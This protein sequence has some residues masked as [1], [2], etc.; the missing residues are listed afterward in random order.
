[1]RKVLGVLGAAALFGLPLWGAETTPD[2]TRNV[3]EICSYEQVK[4]AGAFMNL[5]LT[6]DFSGSMQDRV[7]S[8]DRFYNPSKIYT[9]Y[10]DPFGVYKK[11]EDY[12]KIQKIELCLIKKI[13]KK[14]IKKSIV[15]EE[16]KVFD[17]YEKVSDLAHW[18]LSSKE[19]LWTKGKVSNKYYTGNYLN[20]KYLQRA[21]FEKLLLTGGKVTTLKISS[22]Y[23]GTVCGLEFNFQT[24]V[25]DNTVNIAVPVPCF[26][27]D[28]F[29]KPMVDMYHFAKGVTKK[30]YQHH[31]CHLIPNPKMRHECLKAPYMDVVYKKEYQN[32]GEREVQVVEFNYYTS[33]GIK[34][35]Y[36]RATDTTS[37]NPVTGAVEGILQ[38]LERQPY[39]PRVGLAIFAEKQEYYKDYNAD[40]LVKDTLIQKWIYPSYDYSFVIG[41]IN[42]AEASGGTPTGETLGEIKRY[43]A[44]AEN[45]TWRVGDYYKNPVEGEWKGFSVNDEDYVNPYV[46]PAEDNSANVEVPDAKN[47][48]LLV[49]DGAWNGYGKIYTQWYLYYNYY[50]YKLENEGI[51]VKSGSNWTWL[52]KCHAEATLKKNLPDLDAS[53]PY[54]NCAVDPVEPVFEMWKNGN[55]DLVPSIPGNQKVET[56]VIAT[57]IDKNSLGY[58]AL[59]NIAYYGSCKG[60]NCPTQA[61]PEPVCSYKQEPPCGSFNNPQTT[62]GNFYDVNTA[63]DYYKNLTAY[64][65]KVVKDATQYACESQIPTPEPPINP[66]L[67]ELLGNLLA[68]YSQYQNLGISQD[69]IREYL[70]ILLYQQKA[71][72]ILKQQPST[73]IDKALE[74]LQQ[75]ED[76]KLVISQFIKNSVKETVQNTITWIKNQINQNNEIASIVAGAAEQQ[77]IKLINNSPLSENEKALL[78]N[79]TINIS[80]ETTKDILNTNWT[81]EKK[82]QKLAEML[83]LT[84]ETLAKEQTTNKNKQA[85]ILNIVLSNAQQILEKTNLF[86]EDK[87]EL[88]KK[89]IVEPVLTETVNDISKKILDDLKATPKEYEKLLDLITKAIEAYIAADKNLPTWTNKVK[90]LITTLESFSCKTAQNACKDNVMKVLQAV[91]CPRVKTFV[92]KQLNEAVAKGDRELAKRI[93]SRYLIALGSSGVSAQILLWLE[94]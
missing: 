3:S 59:Q 24:P 87:A 52:L 39:R 45:G 71:E 78:I 1:M 11:V 51:E 29:I 13:I 93:L 41:A 27:G 28:W 90:D 32:A 23:S 53:K 15:R 67:Q 12:Q 14:I 18:T 33:S 35:I 77:L 68:I 9:G 48:V 85:T 61:P 81:L 66:Q 21:N 38:K 10:F 42:D 25:A 55:A 74:Q 6:L 83:K 80:V 5:F 50:N 86:P 69:A 70:E 73:A 44:L 17:F 34:K 58:N 89:G 8:T 16:K 7:Y 22:P 43:F 84:L 40:I 30:H 92:I 79:N 88:I 75:G 36:I 2:Y 54:Y 64:L 72:N 82:E 46:F 26:I 4:P 94:Y 76:I 65:E 47:E 31:L 62:S 56:S 63:L 37:Y 57:F 49:S 60:N 19:N 91:C 20:W